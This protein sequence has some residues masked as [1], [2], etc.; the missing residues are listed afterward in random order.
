MAKDSGAA[1]VDR[2]GAHLEHR[3]MHE[4]EAEGSLADHLELASR[5]HVGGLATSTVAAAAALDACGFPL[6]FIETVG[7]GQSE[8]E[9]ALLVATNSSV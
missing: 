7:T 3:R 8:V 4:I 9:I 6:L 2:P 5:G 1:V